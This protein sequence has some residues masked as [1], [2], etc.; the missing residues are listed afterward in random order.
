MNRFSAKNESGSLMIESIVAASLVVVGILGIMSLLINSAHTSAGATNRLIAA[1][2][3]SEGIEVV[4]NILDTEY[5]EG[6]SFAQDFTPGA[7][8]SLSY[9]STS[10]L[11]AVGSSTPV[12][13]TP[14]HLFCDK[15]DPGCG[16]TD[17][18]FNRAVRIGN[19]S[20]PAVLDVQSVVSWTENGVP[21]TFTLE[22]KFTG[23][24]G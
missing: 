16:G 4:K 10:T 23:W 6:K 19:S 7:T 1:Y 11:L 17:T 8:Y 22:D 18:L 13:I 20:N 21:K 24:R 2:L 5:L 14:A 9:D 12:Q 3:A 15:L